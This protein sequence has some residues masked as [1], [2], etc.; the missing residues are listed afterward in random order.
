MIALGVLVGVAALGVATIGWWLAA[1]GPSPGL[2]IATIGAPLT[3]AAVGIGVATIRLQEAS[4][5]LTGAEQTEQLTRGYQQLGNS[6]GIGLAF[7][8]LC[9]VVTI[10]SA[11]RA[12]RADRPLTHWLAVFPG[13]FLFLGYIRLG[14]AGLVL[15]TS[16]QGPT[17]M[18]EPGTAVQV[19]MLVM[20]G[21]LMLAAQG[22]AALV[23][24][25]L[26]VGLRWQ[27]G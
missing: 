14:L 22:V 26:G 20:L 9:T 21:T 12:R 24:V 4:D 25:L 2:A 27:R 6:I 10:A 1:E 15:L 17:T 5:N 16:W 13:G 8:I 19:M 3:G 23:S 11:V 18:V 7:A